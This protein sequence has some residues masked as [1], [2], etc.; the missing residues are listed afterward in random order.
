MAVL[1]A[2]LKTFLDLVETKSFTVAAQRNGISQAAIT[3]E[4]Q[5]MERHL[6]ARFVDRTTRVFGLTQEGKI[7]R[8]YARKIV[9]AYTNFK[10]QLEAIPHPV[11]TTT[12]ADGDFYQLLAAICLKKKA[13]SPLVKQCITFLKGAFRP[14]VRNVDA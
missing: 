11:S 13:G 1:I 10:S 8:D 3:H 14:S 4:L 7:L 5:S 6:N 9:R 2:H 12:I